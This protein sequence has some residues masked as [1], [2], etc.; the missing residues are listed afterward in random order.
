MTPTGSYGFLRVPIRT[1]GPCGSMAG[2]ISD[3]D[4]D[5]DRGDD[6]GAGDDDHVVGD[7]D[8]DGG[9]N[10]GEDDGGSEAGAQRAND[11]DWQQQSSATGTRRV[12]CPA[13][14][15]TPF[16]QAVP[17]PRGR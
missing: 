9:G 4:D 3:H 1:M 12:A 13:N 2:A 14:G 17:H 5:D 15:M 7:D 6:V 10:H 8:E 11:S 16:P